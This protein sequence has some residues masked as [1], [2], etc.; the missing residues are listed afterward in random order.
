MKETIRAPPP[1][2]ARGLL[3]HVKTRS[4]WIVMST[5]C[6]DKN[7]YTIYDGT[8]LVQGIALPP[9]SMC[10]ASAMLRQAGRGARSRTATRTP[11]RGRPQAAARR[12]RLGAS[13]APCAPHAAGARSPSRAQPG[14]H[15]MEMKPDAEHILPQASPQLAAIRWPRSARHEKQP[16]HSTHGSPGCALGNPA[17]FLRFARRA[18]QLQVGHP[19]Q[20]AT[21]TTHREANV[22]PSKRSFRAS[23]VM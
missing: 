9:V 11:G 8:E 4:H 13:T 12:A 17:A 5:L 7:G 20:N 3:P 23:S 16:N 22:H 14:P 10:K 21:E 6:F 1:V 19:T 18:G 15:A 2:L